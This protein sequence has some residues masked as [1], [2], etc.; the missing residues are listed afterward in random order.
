MNPDKP[1]I[2]PNNQAENIDDDCPEFD[3]EG[4]KKLIEKESTEKEPITIDQL[5]KIN[6]DDYPIFSRQGGVREKS[7]GKGYEGRTL[8]INETLGL[9]VGRT[10]E[11]ISVISGEADGTPPFDHV[12]Y[13]DK[14]ARPVSWLVDEFWDDFADSEQPSKSFLAIDRR[15]WFKILKMP[16]LPNEYIEAPDGSTHLIGPDDVNAYFHNVVDDKDILARI[17][18][19]FIEGGIGT[20]DPDTILNTP[21]VLDGKR[22]LIIDEVKRSGSTLHIA[23]RLLKAA[24][25]ELEVV[26]G[27][28]FW[29]DN[30]MPNPNTDERQMGFAP[31]W[32]PTDHS[33]W[34]G[35][36]VKDI[37]PKYYE[38]Q[39]DNDPTPQNRALKYGAFVLGEPLR[40]ED[41]PGQL[42]QHLAEEIHRMHDDYEA[43]HILP[44]LYWHSPEKQLKRMEEQGVKFVPAEE[45]FKDPHSYL[46]LVKKRDELKK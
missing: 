16:I 45:A 19:L 26:E 44:Q 25:P 40:P 24:I 30:E 6:P 35:R 28:T 20:E 39:F 9:M 27:H 22:L 17:R 1:P 42:S 14:S 38:D 4:A 10:A 41:E 3:P 37:N 33:D 32:Y 13:L 5:F 29:S 18:A 12:I 2:T 46:S 7:Y 23:K 21:T 43:G 15:V 31:V 11:T 8:G 36:G 34:R